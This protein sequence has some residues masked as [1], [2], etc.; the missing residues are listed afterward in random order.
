MRDVIQLH[1]RNQIIVSS[2]EHGWHVRK[3]PTEKT[4]W[5]GHLASSYVD[6]LIERDPSAQVVMKGH[7]ALD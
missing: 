2:D 5:K 3:G 1:P 7:V 4:F 6:Y